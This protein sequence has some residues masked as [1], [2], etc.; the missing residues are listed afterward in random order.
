MSAKSFTFEVNRSSSAAPE[1]LFALVS[2]GSRWPE[3]AKPLVVSGSMVTE[4]NPA[5]GGVGAIRKL[6]VGPVG[7]K[8]QTTAYEQDRLHAYAMLT[9]GPAKDYRAEVRLTPREDGGT[10]LRW[11]GKFNEGVP[12]T[13]KIVQRS[14]SKLIGTFATKLVKAAE[15]TGS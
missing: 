15:R 14:L 12:G 4:G 11:T 10:D 2:D 7:V 6:G 1:K 8:E 3:W 9:P 13:G 5:P